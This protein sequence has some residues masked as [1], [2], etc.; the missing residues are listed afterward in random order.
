MNLVPS[1]F[2]NT[3]IQASFLQ[4]ASIRL[5]IYKSCCPC[6]QSLDVLSLGLVGAAAGFMGRRGSGN[7]QVGGWLSVAA[8]AAA[9]AGNLEAEE[10]E[11]EE[12]CR[13]ASCSWTRARRSSS[14]SWR[15]RFCSCN[16]GPGMNER[17][18]LT[19]M[20]SRSLPSTLT[21]KTPD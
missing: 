9:E 8:A 6:D 12:T 20:E 11:A 14:K 21:Y 4:S 16:D 19:F 13:K 2:L 15:N 18:S 17:L 7:C 5:Y 10:E 3:E 1:F